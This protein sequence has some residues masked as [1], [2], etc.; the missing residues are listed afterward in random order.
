MA[1]ISKCGGEGCLKRDRCERFTALSNEYWQS[2][3]DHV[4]R[5]QEGKECEDFVENGRVVEIN[6]NKCEK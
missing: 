3:S 1:D 4:G 6:V 2:Y 5:V